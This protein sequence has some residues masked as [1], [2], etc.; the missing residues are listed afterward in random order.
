MNVKVVSRY[1]LLAGLLA[2]NLGNGPAK[3]QIEKA[4]TDF[5]DASYSCREKK[6]QADCSKFVALFESLLSKGN[7]KRSFDT[8]PVFDVW[9]CS[10]IK[11]ATSL[12]LH[13]STLS[14]LKSKEAQLLFSS[15][16]LR[17]TMDASIAEEH[18]ASSAKLEKSLKKKSRK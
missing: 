7:C 6:I 1:V 10:S 2:L 11:G 9:Y 4:C 12:D 8:K 17:D 15:K 3:C 18:L 16:K 13:Y 5:E 14:K